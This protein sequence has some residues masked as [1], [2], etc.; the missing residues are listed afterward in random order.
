[1]N[2]INKNT[3]KFFKDSLNDLKGLLPQALFYQIQ[4]EIHKDF[5]LKFKLF[6]KIPSDFLEM[7]VENCEI[8]TSNTLWEKDSTPCNLFFICKGTIKLITDKNE[9]VIDFEEHDIVGFREFQT[10]I[11]NKYKIPIAFEFISIYKDNDESEGSMNRNNNANANANA[12]NNRLG[13][14]LNLANLVNNEKDS[15]KEPNNQ[16]SLK[17]SN[18]NNNKEIFSSSIGSI[19][20]KNTSTKNL[21]LNTKYN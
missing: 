17:D 7:F 14:G 15:E 11:C 3:E 13:R 1:L 4:K 19:K 8:G 2:D 10:I 5:L 20:N 12:L 9:I 6:P 18:L 21:K 16:I